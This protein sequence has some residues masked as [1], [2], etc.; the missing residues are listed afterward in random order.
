MK[1]YGKELIL[2]ISVCDSSKFNRESITKYFRDICNLIGMTREK[3]YWW[4]YEGH[5]EEYEKAPAHLKGISAIQ[6]IK[7]SN[8]TI[9]A[10][11]VLKKVFINIFSCKDF[12]EKKAVEFS[13]RWFCGKKY[14]FKVIVR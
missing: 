11:D 6:F 3:L 12:D 1:G 10:L 5:P 7:T 8:I 4:D 13:R 14:K 2:D 9:H